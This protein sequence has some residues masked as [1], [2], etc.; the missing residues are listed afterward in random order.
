MVVNEI[1][2]LK[3]AWAWKRRTKAFLRCFL[4]IQ[5]NSKVMV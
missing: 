5:K 4:K 3:I 1:V 2:N